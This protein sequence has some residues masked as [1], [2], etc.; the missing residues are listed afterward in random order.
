MTNREDTVYTLPKSIKVLRLMFTVL[1]DSS[2]N[3]ACC[4]TGSFLSAVPFMKSHFGFRNNHLMEF[5]D[6][7]YHYKGEEDTVFG[8]ENVIDL[9]SL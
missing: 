4:S 5:C 8:D 9:C 3:R 6:G 2:W 7:H 1:P